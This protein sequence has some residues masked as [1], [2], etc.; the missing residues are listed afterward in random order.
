[1]GVILVQIKYFKKLI[2]HISTSH[3]LTIG[4][5]IYFINILDSLNNYIYINIYYNL[6]SGILRSEIYRYRT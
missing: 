4:V 3:T 2:F 5:I 1:M 6:V